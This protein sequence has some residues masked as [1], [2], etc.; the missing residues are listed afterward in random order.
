VIHCLADSSPD[1]FGANSN[2]R[3]FKSKRR[4]PTAPPHDPAN[5]T[6]CPEVYEPGDI[7][8]KRVHGLNPMADTQLER[9]LRNSGITT[10]IIAGVS[11]NVAILGLAM[12]AVNSG[13]QVIVA[14]DAVSGY[15]KEYHEPV[16]ANTLFMIATIATTDEII[17]GWP[18]TSTT[19][20]A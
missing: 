14:S 2:A 6:P 16:M 12:D 5:D 20:Q 19:R 7:L 3:L 15:P 4:D 8:S 11:L 18:K 17:A 1:R 13:Y 10:I 9:R